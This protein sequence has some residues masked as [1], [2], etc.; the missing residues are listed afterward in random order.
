[1][2]L[3]VGQLARAVMGRSRQGLYG[4]KRILSGNKVS[5]DG[6]NKYAPARCDAF[7]TKQMAVKVFV[8]LLTYRS[9]RTWKPNVQKMTLYSKMLGKVQLKVTTHALR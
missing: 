5:E 3:G 1:M 2:P 6:G 7:A 8:T 4:G 9:R